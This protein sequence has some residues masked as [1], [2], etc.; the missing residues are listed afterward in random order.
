MGT[1]QPIL[2]E[3]GPGW[4][5]IMTFGTKIQNGEEFNFTVETLGQCV[6][7]FAKV[8]SERR[9]GLDAEHQVLHA[10]SNGQPAP[11][12]GF[13]S[14]AALIENGAI[15]KHWDHYP[16]APGPDCADL[17][18]R[19]QAKFPRM[20]SVDGLWCY[21]REVTPLGLDPDK[22][23][24]NYHQLS[25]FFAKNDRSEDGS[26]IGYA[27]ANV[28]VVGVAFQ[29]GTVMFS[30]AGR[31]RAEDPGVMVA[32]YP[33]IEVCQRVA[34]TSGE[35]PDQMHV[36]LAYLG[37][38]SKLPSYVMQRAGSCLA[39]VVAK[40]GALRG[41][42]G[43]IGRFPASET[44]DGK[45]VIYLPV[46]VPGLAE[47]RHEIV[48]ALESHESGPLKIS[49]THGFTPHMTL[50]YVEPGSPT[51]DPHQ[52]VDVA[53]DR[54]AIVCGAQRHDFHLAAHATA[55]GIGDG[56]LH[57][58]GPMEADDKHK[59]QSAT[60]APQPL[61]NGATRMEDSAFYAKLGIEPTADKAT[62]QAK[63]AAYA[64][65]T[66]DGPEE[67]KAVAAKMGEIMA[68]MGD[69]VIEIKH[70]GDGDGQVPGAVADKDKDGMAAKFSDD[71]DKKKEEA[72][73]S[74][75]QAILSRNLEQERTARLDAERRIAA[76]EAKARGEAVAAF[77]KT[78]QGFEGVTEKDA[79]EILA[80]FGG[81]I[82]KAVAFMSKRLAK[83]QSGAL[84][85]ITDG[86]FPAGTG[87]R[88]SDTRETVTAK[89][90]PT[91]GLGAHVAAKVYMSKNQ[92]TS[93]SDALKAV[94]KQTPGL[95]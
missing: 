19:A 14:G 59:A 80:D 73:M 69:E 60:Q 56:S 68:K 58:P 37:R 29:D 77:H 27:L 15:L 89:G 75:A 83:K 65:E 49:R 93:Y 21:L 90:T 17:L 67:R 34:M 44:S 39:A 62:I 92:G 41:T 38:L 25:P 57:V 9:M 22:G 51:P 12:L 32:L 61:S 30:K 53:F 74:R 81:N 36:T 20:T 5:R 66:P 23:L 72:A 31:D 13:Y 26:P 64:V 8:Y 82:D 3:P 78:A 54:V 52:P 16:D 28:S 88:V 87:E 70:D 91:H 79:T 84:G 43:G 48:V 18:A 42:M 35:S 76:L 94:T 2:T 50:A 63:C 46:D 6:D 11:Q 86:G 85:R 24:A 1:E 7:N 40:H 4:H 55:M 95:Y 33:P 47:L 45:D 10:P 71:E